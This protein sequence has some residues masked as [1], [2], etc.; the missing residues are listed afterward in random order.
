M[1]LRERMTTS[2]CSCSVQEESLTPA[3][4]CASLSTDFPVGCCTVW[5]TC[6]LSSVYFKAAVSLFLH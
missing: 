6:M 1:V 2:T 4:I 3:V 5:L